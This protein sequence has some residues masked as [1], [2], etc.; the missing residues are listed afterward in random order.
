MKKY[1]ES[2]F[3]N[4]LEKMVV[5]KLKQYMKIFR[6]V[7]FGLIITLFTSW[8]IHK[9]YV[10]T[11]KIEYVEKI[12][13]VQIISKIFIDDLEEVLRKRYDESLVLGPEN[14][15]KEDLVKHYLMQKLKITINGTPASLEFIGKEYEIDVVKLYFE[16]NNVRDFNTIEIENMLLFEL[17]NEQKNIIHFKAGKTKRSLVLTKENTK[18]MLNFN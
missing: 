1:I 8:T 2:R 4:F 3:T 11:T 16:I 13:S 17:S 9:F 14:E 12:Q 7:V 18:V 5:G 6:I 15:T 10:S